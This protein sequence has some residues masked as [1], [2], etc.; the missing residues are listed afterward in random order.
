MD[1]ALLALPV[2]VLHII[3]LVIPG[4]DFFMVVKNS[5]TGSRKDGILTASGIALGV[6]IHIIYC[7]A[8]FAAIISQSILLFTVFKILAG[9]YLIYLG[10]S[11]LMAKHPQQNIHGSP[12]AGK[13]SFTEG[14]V[15]NVL[16]PKASLA[17][18][19]IFTV[20]LPQG[21]PLAEMLAI[22]GILIMTT[23]MWFAFVSVA[24]TTETVRALYARFS[25]AATK[26][27]GAILLGL[28]IKLIIS[29]K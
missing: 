4:P 21:V 15:T 16:N 8:G 9:I 12:S 7:A 17:F 18:L 10:I 1:F 11:A 5:V 28:G 19:S 22:A 2:I 23:F 6:G 13:N 14:F 26:I 20:V 3:A 25:D 27:F 24:L 29:E